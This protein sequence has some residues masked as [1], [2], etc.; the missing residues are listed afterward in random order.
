M[1]FS[2]ENARTQKVWFDENNMW[3]LLIDG[4]QLSIPKAYFPTFK[5]VSNET[6]S[7]YSLSG[8][9]IGIHWDNLDEDLYVPNLLLGIYSV[10]K[11]PVSA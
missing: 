7:D 1:N 10:E 4:R 2:V 6:L 5:D 8:G 3:L 11:K 9:G